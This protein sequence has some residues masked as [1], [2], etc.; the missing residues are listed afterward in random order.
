M[1]LHHLT[2]C[3]VTLCWIE[4]VYPSKEKLV[5]QSPPDLLLQLHD[6]AKLTLTHKIQSY[7]TILWYQRSPGDSSLKLIGYMSYKNPNIEGGFVGRF[8]VSGDGENTAHLHILNLTGA[9]YNG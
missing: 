1:K 2:V 9:E 4:G 5:F 3:I 6:A 8:E 7:D